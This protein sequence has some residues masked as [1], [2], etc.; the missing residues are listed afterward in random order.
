MSNLS[1]L[2]NILIGVIK[3]LRYTKGPK[4][5]PFLHFMFRALFL[6][7]FFCCCLGAEVPTVL[8]TV[9]PHQFFV[10]KIAGKS[11]NVLL[12]VPAGA[13]AHSYEPSP[14][15]MIA[16]SK[17]LLWFRI[18]ESFETKAIEALKSHQPRL[19]IVDLRQGLDL[20]TSGESHCRCC[21]ESGADLHFWLSTR[22][23]KIQA[24]TIVTALTGAF[25][26]NRE[27]YE[28]NVAIFK[29]ELDDLDKKIEEILKPLKNRN[30][31]VS[32]PAYAYFCRDYDLKQYSIEFEGKDP[33]PQY[34]T[35]ILQLAR[36][37]DIRTVY[38][39]LQYNNK[40]ARLIADE[41]HA[42]VV[43]LDPY[44]EN[45]LESM[46]QIAHAFSKG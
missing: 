16:A 27:L 37:L 7:F 11:V 22:Q 32:H 20:I 14:K 41:I 26:E 28:K 12:M 5:S 24:E 25:P 9:A 38:I 19:K 4:L 36:D 46:L 34:L 21:L 15:Q 18:G 3:I 17:A 45:Y 13:S 31:L 39:Q 40:G 6:S 33:T 8:V 42:K 29:A 43:V 30:I 2:H 35:K 23:A 1:I 10:E 44:G